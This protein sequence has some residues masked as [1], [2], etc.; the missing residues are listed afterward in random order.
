MDG[1]SVSVLCVQWEG[2]ISTSG[3]FFGVTGTIDIFVQGLLLEI[4]NRRGIASATRRKLKKLRHVHIG[5]SNTS[6]SGGCSVG[7]GSYTQG[8]RRFLPPDLVVVDAIVAGGA[9]GGLR[10][11]LVP[12]FLGFLGGGSFAWAGLRLVLRPSVFVAFATPWNLP[13]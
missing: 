9:F 6:S 2:V 12:T 1:D 8:C 10:V 11:R 5:K 7:T 3:S 4:G 13:R